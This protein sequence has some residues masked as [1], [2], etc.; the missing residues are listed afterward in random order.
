[1]G[2][3]LS[4]CSV[5]GAKQSQDYGDI[6]IRHQ[7]PTRLCCLLVRFSYFC[8]Y[9]LERTYEEQSEKGAP[10]E[11]CLLITKQEKWVEYLEK[12]RAETNMKTYDQ[13]DKTNMTSTNHS[14]AQVKKRIASIITNPNESWSERKKVSM[15]GI[16]SN[17]FGHYA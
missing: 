2:T 15:Y 4:R 14:Q 12:R 16:P 5:R 10:R 17:Y 1:M 9:D 7:P 11:K 3:V 13:H 6:H 8:V